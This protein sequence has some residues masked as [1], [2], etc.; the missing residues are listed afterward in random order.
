M[1]VAVIRRSRYYSVYNTDRMPWVV[2]WWQ[3]LIK[4]GSRP[5]GADRFSGRTQCTAI[6]RWYYMFLLLVVFTIINIAAAVVVVM[7]VGVLR[8]RRALTDMMLYYYHTYYIVRLIGAGPEGDRLD[9][10]RAEWDNILIVLP[11]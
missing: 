4:I 9:V 7:I 8:W 5:T 1:M 3:P 10:Y 11:W 6:H 2:V